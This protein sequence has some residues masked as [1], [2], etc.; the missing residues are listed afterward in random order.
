MTLWPTRFLVFCICL[1]FSVQVAWADCL[2]VQD[3]PQLEINPTELQGLQAIGIDRSLIFA[4]MRETSVPETNGCWSGASGDFDGQLVSVGLAQWNYGQGSLQ[5]LLKRYRAKFVSEQ[6][7]QAELNRLAPTYGKLLFSR[8]CLMEPVSAECA[9]TLHT[10][11]SRPG[12]VDA[13]LAAEY[14]TLFESLPMRQVQTDTFVRLLGQVRDALAH[15]Y[16]GQH[17]SPLQVK[18]AIDSKVQLGFPRVEDASRIRQRFLGYSAQDRRDALKAMLQWY[19]GL[20]NSADQQGARA[21][22]AFNVKQWT[23]LI[24]RGV[25]DEQADLLNLSFIRSRTAQNKA[26]LYQALAFQRRAKIV[27][28]V[29]S[30]A[31]RQDGPRCI[32]DMNG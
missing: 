27:L 25:S 20:A 24:D 19:S 22:A 8:G 18:W 21:D 1:I 12:H 16:P 10:H 23:C 30:V 9:A 13:D 2:K 11:Q 31:K 7:F 15:L 28:G 17:V 6:L 5:P 4:S 29:G 14:N 3:D 32:T 26:G